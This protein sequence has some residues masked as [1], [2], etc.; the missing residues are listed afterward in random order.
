VYTAVANITATIA[1]FLL[2]RM[3]RLREV[4]TTP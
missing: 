1:Y 3:T 2:C 4:R